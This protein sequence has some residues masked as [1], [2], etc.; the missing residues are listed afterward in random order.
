MKNYYTIH[1]YANN[2]FYGEKKSNSNYLQKKTR[3]FCPF[4]NISELHLHYCLLIKYKLNGFT[5][6]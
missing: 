4:L 1:N 3:A 5:S 2:T 6:A